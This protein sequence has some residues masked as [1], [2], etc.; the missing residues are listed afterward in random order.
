MA[1]PAAHNGFVAGSIPAA[2]TIHRTPNERHLRSTG[3]ERHA[4]TDHVRHSGAVM[5][6]IR[7]HV[8]ASFR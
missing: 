7:S 5:G 8:A 1:E 6:R 3:C 4:V 2:P